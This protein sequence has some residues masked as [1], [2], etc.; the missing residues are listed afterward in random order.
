MYVFY[1]GDYANALLHYEKGLSSSSKVIP[2]TVCVSVIQH[3]SDF[4]S[5]N[6]LTYSVVDE[7]RKF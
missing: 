2:T 7:G 4:C 3:L 5:T 1:S 6:K